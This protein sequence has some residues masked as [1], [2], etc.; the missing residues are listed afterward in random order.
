MWSRTFG[1]WRSLMAPISLLHCRSSFNVSSID[2]RASSFSEIMIR[3]ASDWHSVSIKLVV[4]VV[5]TLPRAKV[6]EVVHELDGGDP[7]HHPEAQ[8][9]LAAQAQRCAMHD[10]KRLVVHL[11]GQ[12]GQLVP[13]VVHWMDLVIAPAVVAEGH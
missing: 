13:Q 8:L 11:V 1:K 4:V 10:A 6:G 5:T 12:D 7:F 2:L 9:V 3:S